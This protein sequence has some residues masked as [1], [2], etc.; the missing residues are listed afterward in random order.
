MQKIFNILEEKNVILFESGD[1]GKKNM[2]ESI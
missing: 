1:F 2:L